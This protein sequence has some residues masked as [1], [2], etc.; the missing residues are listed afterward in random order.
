[1]AR[2]SAMPT[3][4]RFENRTHLVSPIGGS[5]HT[6]C[7]VAFDAGGSEDE[8]SLTWK[9]TT[10]TTV[11]CPWCVLVIRECKGVKTRDV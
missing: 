9:V 6:L 2:R 1:M 11:T 7:G 8:P 5:E 10:N 3:F 4:V